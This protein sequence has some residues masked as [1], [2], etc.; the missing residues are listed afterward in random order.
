METSKTC[1][2]KEFHYHYLFESEKD[3]FIIHIHT[4]FSGHFVTTAAQA[5]NSIF[6]SF[7]ISKMIWIFFLLSTSITNSITNLTIGIGGVNTDKNPFL[8]HKILGIHLCSSKE[9]QTK[10]SLR[11]NQIVLKFKENKNK[12]GYYH[13]DYCKLIYSFKEYQKLE[14]LSK[15]SY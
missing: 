15:D 1:F 6:I 9:I 5:I 12:T 3:I 11:E 8:S 13:L 14:S 2:W 4:C 10:Y 7:T